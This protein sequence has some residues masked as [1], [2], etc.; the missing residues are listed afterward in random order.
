VLGLPQSTLEAG[1]D[2]YDLVTVPLSARQPDTWLSMGMR[3]DNSLANELREIIDLEVTLLSTRNDHIEVLGTSIFS[4]TPREIAATL[5]DET[6]QIVTPQT[7]TLSGSDY[8]VLRQPFG[9]EDSNVV[10]VLK[11]SLYEA[12]GPY[13]TLRIATIILGSIALLLAIFGAFALAGAITRPVHR[14]ARTARR[15]TDGDYSRSI[16]INSDDEL[17]ELAIAFSPREFPA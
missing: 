8:L 16:E 1:G 11:K 7:R 9:R 10:V 2:T 5:A 17:A 14:L 13:R 6:Y 3:I 4:A 15:I 12:M